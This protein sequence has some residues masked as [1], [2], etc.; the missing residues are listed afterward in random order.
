MNISRRALMRTVPLASAA[1]GLALAGCSGV[2][3]TTITADIL[4]YLGDVETGLTNLAPALEE[5]PGITASTVAS[6]NDDLAQA[7][8]VAQTIS[9]ATT[10]AAAQSAIGQVETYVS[11]GLKLLSGFTLP[12]GVSTIVTA[13]N[14]ALPFVET[15]VA[16]LTS[17]AVGVAPN[18]AALNALATL[19]N[20]KAVLG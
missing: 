20:S 14:I 17:A 16:S 7:L 4:T 12:S 3:A 18:P 11:A 9:S 15:A 2:S 6:I 13:L 5:I 1:A 8:T 19:R 10:A